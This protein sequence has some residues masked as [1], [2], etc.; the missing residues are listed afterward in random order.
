MSLRNFLI[1]NFPL[2]EKP[3]YS[4]QGK[5]HIVFC[6]PCLVQLSFRTRNDITKLV[7]HHYSGIKLWFIYK[8][9]KGL[10]SLFT[11]KDLFPSLVCSNNPHLQ[12]YH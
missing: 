4:K 11:Y 3:L 12:G 7:I 9:S 6:I 8:S 1:N 10:S 2:P 5:Q